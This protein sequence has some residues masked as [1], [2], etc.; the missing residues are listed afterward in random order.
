VAALEQVHG[1]G[2]AEGH[3]NDVPSPRERERVRGKCAF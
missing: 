2:M 3:S 1:L